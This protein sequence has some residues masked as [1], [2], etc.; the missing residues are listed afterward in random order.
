MTLPH[1]TRLGPY[2]VI[3]PLGSGG[4][5]EVY[6][7]RDT[8]LGREV[9]VKVLPAE[10]LS[11]K[12][13]RARFVQEARAASALNHPNIVTIHEIESVEGI[14]FIVME[15]VPGCTLNDLIPQQGMRLSEALRIAIPLADALAAAHAAGIVHRDLKPGNVMVR[16]DGVVKVLDFG[17]AKLVRGDTGSPGKKT[18]TVAGDVGSLS[19]PGAVMGTTG[20]MSPEQ[21]SGGRVDARSDVFSFG[22]LLYEM[23]TGRRAFA[24]DSGAEVLAALLKDRPKPPRELAPDVPQALE[25]IILRCLRKERDRRFQTMLDVKIELQEVKE[26]SDSQASTLSGAE[27]AAPERRASRRRGWTLLGAAVILVVSAG[28]TGV[29]WW[30]GRTAKPGPL[31]NR[32]VVAVFENH[33]GDASLESLGRIAAD[34]ISDGLTRVPGVQVV[35]GA[36]VLLDRSGPRTPDVKNS[37]S[38][39]IQQLA[40]ATGAGLVVSGIYSLTGEDFRIQPRL[41]DATSGQ[42]QALDPAVGPRS[43]PMTVVESARQRL[44]GAVAVRFDPNWLGAPDASPPTYEAYQEYRVF[45]E[46]GDDPIPRLRRVVDLD[47]DFVLARIELIS[48]SLASGDYREAARHV[49]ALE[50]RKARLTPAQRL[51]VDA[52]RASLVGRT[53]EAYLAARAARKLWPA[54]TGMAV[55]FSWFARNAYRFH[56]ATEALTAPLDWERSHARSRFRGGVYFFDL[57]MMLHWLGE[58]ERELTELRRGQRLHPEISSLYDL[59]AYALTAL[60]QVDEMERL[61]TERLSLASA[62]QRGHLLLYIGLELRVHGRRDASAK[63]LARSL[64]AL[65]G[66][67]PEEAKT[68]GTRAELAT[69]FRLAGRLGEASAIYEQLARETPAGSEK[70]LV[71]AGD[72]GVVAAL[73][74]DHAAALRISDELGRLKRPFL[75]GVNVYERARIAAEV[76]EQDRAVD[77]LRVA[78]ARGFILSSQS[79]SLHVEPSFEAL[80]GYPP[81]EEAIKP[82]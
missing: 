25:R 40:R 61:V 81:F 50:E 43:A 31:S 33:T 69:L 54:D 45:I 72:L 39:P 15:L 60:G 75:F 30:R 44:M 9:A 19:R 70:A 36:K 28:A 8:R 66:C 80:R 1:G 77:L 46:A 20:Y 62:G 47:P 53:G 18:T 12:A 49:A 13:R 10:R 42:V 82:Q 52:H 38:D 32:I 22:V 2:E 17:L 59:E 74:G 14:D 78:I 11:D 79:N 64:E 21:A 34:H 6:R 37:G 71:W 57:T 48:W 26:E 65:Q 41:T 35:P 27:A 68:E 55:A 23:V 4:M 5:G 73:R 29:A 16:P 63:M 7:A 56:E 58:H 51:L 67:S 76:G 3:A 24:G